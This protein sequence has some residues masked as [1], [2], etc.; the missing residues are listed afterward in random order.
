[1]YCEH[2]LSDHHVIKLV[3]FWNVYL[4]LGVT[5]IGLHY[6]IATYWCFCGILV[7]S[8][9]IIKF[10]DGLLSFLSTKG[11]FYPGYVCNFTER[12]IF[13]ITLTKQG[14]SF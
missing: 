9:S 6:L 5:M 3:N 12:L 13:Q 11:L 14:V 4:E 1:M 2:L 7:I 10:G 8:Y